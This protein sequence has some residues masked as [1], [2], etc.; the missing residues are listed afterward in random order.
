MLSEAEARLQ[1]ALEEQRAEAEKQQA[2]HLGFI[3]RLL[4]DKD[5][6]TQKCASLAAEIAS[7]ESR[8]AALRSRSTHL[9]RAR[10]ADGSP[11]VDFARACWEGGG[12]E[13][14]TRV[15]SEIPQGFLGWSSRAA[16]AIRNWSR[17]SVVGVARARWMA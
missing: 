2:R 15:L 5:A 7:G 10:R 14:P 8:C 1:A 9:G 17:A 4:A 16:S 13:V 6:L 11:V 12:R 3:D